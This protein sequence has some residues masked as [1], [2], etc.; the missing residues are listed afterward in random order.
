MAVFLNN[1]VGVI[2][3]TTDV[4]SEISGVTLNQ[5]FDEVEV[6]ALGDT[7]HK[8]V[9]GLESG[10]LS[11][12]FFGDFAS[13]GTST[14]LQAAFGTTV[15]VK[16]IPVKGTA[17][18]ATNPLYT[19]TILVNNLTPFNGSVGDINSSSVQFTCNSAIEFAT[20]GTFA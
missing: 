4:S 7:A 20:T 12:D 15:T 10:T 6:S 16:I 13:T 19:T 8:F 2:I 11:L 5:T 9:K 14:I 17:V 18:S 3:G 1:K